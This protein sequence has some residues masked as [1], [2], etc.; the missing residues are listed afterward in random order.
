[1]T[2]VILSVVVKIQLQ[3]PDGRTGVDTTTTTDSSNGAYYTFP[4]V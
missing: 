3:M 2:R 4:E 1:M